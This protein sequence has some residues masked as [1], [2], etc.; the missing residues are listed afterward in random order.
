MLCIYICT[1]A[2]KLCIC[3]FAVEANTLILLPQTFWESIHGQNHWHPLHLSQ[4]LLQQTGINPYSRRPQFFTT[5]CVSHSFSTSFFRQAGCQLYAVSSLLLG[6][7]LYL[8]VYLQKHVV[9]PWC[10]WTQSKAHLVSGSSSA[11]IA[12][13]G[14]GGL[15][16]DGELWSSQNCSPQAIT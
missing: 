2:D 9:L 16:D 10:W 12:L 14:Y 7:I 1:K 8:S 5:T 4:I 15:T 11:V 13:C 3:I 6:I